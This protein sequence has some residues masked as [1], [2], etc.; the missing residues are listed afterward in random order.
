MGNILPRNTGNRVYS[1]RRKAIQSV[2]LMILLNDHSPMPYGKYKGEPLKKVPPDYL[3]WLYYNDRASTGI[4]E[5][6]ERNI[7]ALEKKA[8]ENM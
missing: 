6:V 1:D 2:Q 3:L 8:F 7:E 4:K 5:Y